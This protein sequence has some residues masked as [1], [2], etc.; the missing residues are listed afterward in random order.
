MGHLRR[1][2][3]DRASQYDEKQAQIDLV[4]E[5][6]AGRIPPELRAL[7][8]QAVEHATRLQHVEDFGVER[9][10]ALQ[11]VDRER[12]HH[13]VEAPN[14]GVQW[15]G[16]VVLDELHTLLACKALTRGVQHQLGEVEAHAGRLWAVSAEQAEQSAIA[17][18][19]I[20]NAPHVTRHVI[21][22]HAL[23]LRTMREIVGPL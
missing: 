20:E 12:R 5:A 9:A 16:E 7:V 23:A 11:V 21:E 4:W 19:E 14:A 1:S 3:I 22:Q 10:L 13:G 6:A 8:E 18:P 15:L 17:G 2:N